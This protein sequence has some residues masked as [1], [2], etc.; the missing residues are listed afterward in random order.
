ML[1]NNAWRLGVRAEV[2]V[3]V[4]GGAEEEGVL[5]SQKSGEGDEGIVELK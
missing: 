2:G 5:I 1:S 3:R 4:E